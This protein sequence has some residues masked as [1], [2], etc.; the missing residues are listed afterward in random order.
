MRDRFNS[1]VAR[2]EVAWELT[3]GALAIAYVVIGFSGDD[4]NAPVLVAAELALT[5]VFAVEFGVRFGAARDRG[6]Y[7]RGHWIDLIALIPTIRQLR[8]LRLLRLLRLVRT[9]AAVYRALLHVERVL[10]NRQIAA[11]GVVWLAILL[12]TSLG[13]YAAENGIN[14]EVQTPLDALWWG[15]VTM[16]TV[17]YGD[18][19]PVTPEGRLAASILMVLGIA[20]FGVLTA[21]VT[22]LVLRT[23]DPPAEASPLEQIRELFELSNMGAVTKEEYAA[24]KSELLARVP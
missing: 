24:K 11:I 18:V 16:T 4:V 19:S 2:Y 6:A 7:L 12:L 8:V 20:L 17:G 10:G 15:V 1:F 23:S 21:T 9:F 13:L 3:M 22:G 5:A 14:P